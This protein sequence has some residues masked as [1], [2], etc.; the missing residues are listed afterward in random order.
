MRLRAV[1]QVMSSV[2]RRYF[3][4]V[5][6]FLCL[7]ATVTLLAYAPRAEPAPGQ[8]VRQTGRCCPVTRT[9]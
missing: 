4:R 9:Q 5:A 1:R 8:S 6:L 3:H 7:A 2:R